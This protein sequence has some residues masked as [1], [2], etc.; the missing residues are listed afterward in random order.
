MFEGPASKIAT[1]GVRGTKVLTESRGF[2][3]LRQ[4][5]NFNGSLA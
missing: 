1:S 5:T 2:G 3:Y 4:S